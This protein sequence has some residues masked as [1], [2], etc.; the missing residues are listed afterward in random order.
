MGTVNT[1]LLRTNLTNQR[2]AL[3]E[4]AQSDLDNSGSNAVSLLTQ[5]AQITAVLAE[6]TALGL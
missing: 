6:L 4:A 1:A 5:A 2:D 3:R